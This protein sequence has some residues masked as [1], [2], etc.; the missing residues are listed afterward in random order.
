MAAPSPNSRMLS[1]AGMSTLSQCHQKRTKIKGI[2]TNG[3]GA[4]NPIDIDDSAVRDK[5]DRLWYRIDKFPN[6][7]VPA[8]ANRSFTI[9][10]DA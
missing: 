4:G 5:N 3:C 2:F 8:F 10:G 6:L 9:Y 1:D 7:A